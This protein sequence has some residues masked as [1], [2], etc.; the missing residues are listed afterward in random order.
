MNATWEALIAEYRQ[1]LTAERSLSPATVRAYGVD[2]GR[3]AEFVGVAPG[4]VTLA[5]LR[6]WLGELLTSGAAPATLQRRVSCIKGF[7]AWALREGHLATNPALRLKAHRSR[8]SLPE[9]P[10]RT[11][12]E[13]TLDALAVA[14]AEGEP[15]ALRDVAL[16]E[17]LYSSGLRI[18]ELCDLT[19]GDLDLERSVVRVVGKGGKERS[20]PMGAPARS[21]LQRWLAV[22]P[23][24]ATPQ[25]PNRV[26]LGTRGG[27]LDPRVARR[28]VQGAT[29]AS[30]HTVSPHALRHAM[31][32]HL[33]AG[34][35]DLRSVQEML[36][37]ASIA[38]TQIYTHVSGDR[39]RAAFQQAH[40]R[41]GVTDRRAE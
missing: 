37:H 17:L 20:V 10:T 40:P 7:F 21:A 22:R 24:M 41:A 14:A 2:L 9:A 13:R 39:L 31:A 27:A 18:S 25:S 28:V 4:K 19:P 30:G 15:R 12:M 26:F 34:G 38:T 23:R 29:A 32:T 36:G 8:R 1:H 3:L 16:V 33:L 35:A 6:S 11:E 5:Q